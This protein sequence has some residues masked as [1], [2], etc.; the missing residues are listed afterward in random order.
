MVLSFPVLV[1]Y[2]QVIVYLCNLSR[3]G[4]LWADEH[5]AQGFAWDHSIVSF[6]V[7]DHDGECFIEAD[8]D[9]DP[10][11]TRIDASLW[12]IEVPFDA[13]EPDIQLGTILDTRALK[14]EL[15]KYRLIFEAHPGQIKDDI[16]YAYLLRFCFIKSDQQAFKILKQG[17]LQSDKV[18]TTSA[19]R[20]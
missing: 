7:P 5:V 16:S 11:K 18:L 14:I 3:P 6:G 2:T 9:S 10:S 15:G 13:E 4:L 8:T 19:Q 17:G 20:G 12:A 1:N